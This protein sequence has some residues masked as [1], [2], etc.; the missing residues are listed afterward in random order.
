MEELALI[1][2]IIPTCNDIIN[3]IRLQIISKHIREH[4]VQ[5]L[6][7]ICGRKCESMTEYICECIIATNKIEGGIGV[8][9]LVRGE[10]KFIVLNVDNKEIVC[11][12]IPCH[13]KRLNTGICCITHHRVNNDFKFRCYRHKNNL[14]S[15]DRC[16]YNLIFKSSNYYLFAG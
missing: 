8:I 9:I 6:A 3:L 7:I 10:L 16:K 2:A 11:N 13:R 4:V 5:R 12:S 1:D 15:S 14:V